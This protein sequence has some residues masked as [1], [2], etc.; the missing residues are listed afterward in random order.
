MRFRKVATDAAPCNH[1]HCLLCCVSY[2]DSRQA[3]NRG[4]VDEAA[5]IAFAQGSHL[6]R[7]YFV[8]IKTGLP[9]VG[10]VKP[11][12]QSCMGHPICKLLSYLCRLQP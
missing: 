2:A 9:P 3:S 7:F 6:L 8:H 12:Q 5:G 1:C 11:S 10:Q 4:F